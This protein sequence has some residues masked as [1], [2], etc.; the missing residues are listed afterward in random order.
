MH[1]CS[2]ALVCWE[3]NVKKLKIMRFAWIGMIVILALALWTQGFQIALLLGGYHANDVV[4]LDHGFDSADHE[5]KVIKTSSRMDNVVLVLMRKSSMGVWSISDVGVHGKNGV[6]SIAWFGDEGAKRF[7]QAAELQF[8]RETH[9]IFYG[10]NATKLINFS[11]D[12]L[13]EN[14]TLSVDQ[15]GEVFCIHVT[16]RDQPEQIG[17][18]DVEGVLEESGCLAVK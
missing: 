1:A 6:A 11:P 10:A 4:V 17:K 16:T 2:L 7:S 13:P 14:V 8:F 15:T 3:G 9:A 18:L 5:F 12:V